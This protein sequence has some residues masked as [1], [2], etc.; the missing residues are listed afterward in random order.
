MLLR[1]PEARPTYP[2]D[3]HRLQRQAPVEYRSRRY[4]AKQL[5]SLRH[6]HVRRK[7]RNQQRYKPDSG[8]S[9][10]RWDHDAA[11]TG[12]LCDAAYCNQKRGIWKRRR[13]DALVKGG[14]H[15]MVG[16]RRDKQRTE[17]VRRYGFVD[18]TVV[19]ISQRPPVL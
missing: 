14:V 2:S 19:E 6:V 1:A 7:N 4:V 17:Q 8:D 11:T 3:K 15:E 9:P 12:Y 16:A 13:N 10:R 5:G 18:H